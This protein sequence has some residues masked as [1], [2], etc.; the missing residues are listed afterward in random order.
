MRGIHRVVTVGLGIDQI[1]LGEIT[2]SK[3][4]RCRWLRPVQM[5]LSDRIGVA[6]LEKHLFDNSQYAFPILTFPLTNYSLPAV[7][8]RDVSRAGWGPRFD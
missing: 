5:L 2:K 8:K 4:L 1:R 3:I 7:V 6:A